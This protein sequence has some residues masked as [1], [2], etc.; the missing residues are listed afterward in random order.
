LPK[1][2]GKNDIFAAHAAGGLR[3]LVLQFIEF[4]LG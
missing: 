2:V 3:E 4:A 1:R